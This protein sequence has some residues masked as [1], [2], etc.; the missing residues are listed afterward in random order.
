[1]IL[2][3]KENAASHYW[4]GFLCIEVQSVYNNSM[5][6]RTHFT[7]GSALALLV[8]AITRSIDYAYITF[9]VHLVLVFDFF[10]EK[11]FK[12]EP[13]HSV[14]FMIL[15]TL[16][17]YFV[18]PVYAIF[19]GLGYFSHLFID[20]FADEKLELFFPFSSKKVSLYKKDIENTLTDLSI[21]A[22]MIL[23]VVVYFLMVR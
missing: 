18:Q 10:V 9:F 17:A 11:L 22:V 16:V 5:N 13:F 23:L 19:V 8:L 1:M 20:L 3:S 4:G 2:Y 7:F 12:K 15:A 6:F 21:L 14:S